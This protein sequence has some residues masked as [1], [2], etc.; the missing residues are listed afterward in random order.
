MAKYLKIQSIILTLCL[1][2]TAF[3]GISALADDPF[4]LVNWDADLDYITLDFNQAVDSE[5]AVI[6]LEADGESVDFTIED[7]IFDETAQ[8][9]AICYSYLLTPEGGLEEGVVYELYI[10]TIGN[11]AGTEA[12]TDITKTFAVE[13]LADDADLV[14]INPSANT[15][16][17]WSKN[18]ETNS[19]YVT[20]YTTPTGSG[21]QTY[22]FAGALVGDD[23][24]EEHAL[25]SKDAVS[26]T[27]TWTESD[28]TAKVTFKGDTLTQTTVFFG[29][30]RELSGL[31]NDGDSTDITAIRTYDYTAMSEDSHNSAFYLVNG[32]GSRQATNEDRL[33]NVSRGNAPD[34]D[35]TAGVEFKLSSKDGLV[36]AFV[37]DDKLME[38]ETTV[39]AG[40]PFFAFNSAV[41]SAANLELYD[42]RVTRCAEVSGAEL[43]KEVTEL[44]DSVVV[45]FEEAVA[46]SAADKIAL[47][48]AEGNKVEGATVTLSSD[49][50]Q[51]TVLFAGLEYRT[52]YTIELGTL[53]TEAGSYAYFADLTF[54]TVEPPTEIYSFEVAGGG[55]IEGTVTLE[56]V[57]ANNTQDEDFTF[58]ATIAIY[59][60]RGQMVAVN[61]GAYTLATGESDTVAIENFVCD[62][63]ETYTAKCFV[64]NSLFGMNKIYEATIG[65]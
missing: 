33:T 46:D 17:A 65:E 3:S 52:D 28:Y 7:A 55:E 39:A 56:A 26:G 13:V 8:S 43:D 48:D 61:G 50:T 12:I 22:S 29:I 63:E 62:S 16:A 40:Y 42:F 4:A 58:T 32:N 9:R 49:N 30:A 20:G 25:P 34:L 23:K 5:N 51:A 27:G 44:E 2:L 14:N 53:K 21:I 1:I 37:N 54:C 11:G 15:C 24:D 47:T 41:S 36:R 38:A 31:H 59:N 64:W 10:D 57:L 35:Y 6:T 18:E 45:T 60:S 19:L